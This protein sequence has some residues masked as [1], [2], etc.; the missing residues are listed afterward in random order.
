MLLYLYGPDGYRRSQKVAEIV[1]QYLKKYPDAVP[2]SFSLENDGDFNRLKEFA[3]T[4]SLFAKAKLGILTAADEG[5]KELKDLLKG[6]IEDKETTLIISA[7]KKLP[8]DF[9]FL[10]KEGVK[11]S[12]FEPLEGAKLLS[13]IKS[14][15]KEK[16]WTVSDDVIRRVVESEGDDL[17]LVMTEL[18]RLAYGGQSEGTV[19][20]PDF[21]PLIMSLK[22]SAPI[23]KK[24]N[25]LYFA[26]EKNEPAA[27]FNVLAS[28]L[29]PAGK[30]RFADYD[31]AIKSGKLDYAEALT[32][33]VLSSVN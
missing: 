22:G 32:D 2:Q 5:K 11:S 20:A 26:L 3:T 18:E 25:S 16:S 33:F 28:Q 1:A 9:D 17:W 8:K 14:E 13:F 30:V 31:I 19:V 21:F 24:L 7:E 4:R 10:L 12:E 6:L 27:V 23:Q 29:D 15:I